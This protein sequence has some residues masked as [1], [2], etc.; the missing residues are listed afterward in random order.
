MTA[1][2]SRA[3]NGGRIERPIHSQYASPEARHAGTA[4]KGTLIRT[5]RSGAGLRPVT[6]PARPGTRDVAEAGRAGARLV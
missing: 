2:G 3:V 5:V 6:M 4:P 1:G